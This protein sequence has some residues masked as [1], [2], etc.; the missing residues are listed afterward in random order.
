VTAPAGRR[1][2]GVEREETVTINDRG[3]QRYDAGQAVLQAAVKIERAVV[4]LLEQTADL[5]LPRDH[6]IEMLVARLLVAKPWVID[7]VNQ[8][9]GD[10][11]VRLAKALAD[12]GELW[13]KRVKRRN[14]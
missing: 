13:V 14:A 8:Q 5:Y 9:P 1:Q 2:Q 4:D 3:S 10:V 12:W 7:W 11:S 6:I